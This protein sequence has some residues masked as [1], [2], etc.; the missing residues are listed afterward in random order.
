MQRAGRNQRRR[1]IVIDPGHGGRDPG[2]V[3]VT[4]TR[5]KDVVLDWR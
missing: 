4:G 5:E 2:A 1:T 3:G